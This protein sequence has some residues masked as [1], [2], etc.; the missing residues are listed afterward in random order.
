M[1][2]YETIFIVNPNIADD[3]VEKV[4][5]KM[6]DIV[7]REGGEILKAEN[8]GKRK[9]A[10]E[11]KKQKKGT[12]VYFLYE[13]GPTLVA[14]LERNLRLTDATIKFMTVKLEKD[15]ALANA[16]PVPVAVVATAAASTAEEA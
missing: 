15:A 13:A 9:L 7:V 8:W 4:T 1:S 14:E 12:Y 10:Y 2:V 16:M 6:R 3:E 11:V 5:S